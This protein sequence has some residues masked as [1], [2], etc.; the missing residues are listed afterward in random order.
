MADTHQQIDRE[1][2]AGVEHFDEKNVGEHTHVENLEDA[3][4]QN[5]YAVK[6][7]DSDGK[8]PMTPK[9]F[10]TMVVLAMSYVGANLPLFF[11]GGALTFIQAS[12][13]NPSTTGWA[14]TAYGIALAS[15]TPFTGYLQDLFGRRYISIAGSLTLC[16]GLVII[17]TSH[18]FV[19][20]MFGCVISGVGAGATELTAI[21]GLAEVVSVKNRGLT[22]SLLTGFILPFAPYVLYA[23]LFGENATWRWGMWLSLIYNGLVLVGLITLYFPKSHHRADGVKRAQLHK[24]LDLIGGFL[25]MSGIVLLQVF[26]WRGG[27]IYPWKSGRVLAPMIIGFLLCMS[28]FVWEWKGAKYPM[29]PSNIFKGQRVTGSAIGIAFVVGMNLYAILNFL[30][31]MFA[32]VYSPDAIQVGVKALG[33]GIGQTIGST[34]MNLLMTVFKNHQ[35]ENLLFSCLLMTACISALACVNPTNP[36][37]V[38]VLSAFAGW[39]VGGIIA[40]IATVALST[41]PDAFIATVVSIIQACRFL[42]GAIGYSIYYAVFTGKVKTRLPAAVAKYAVD[43]GLPLQS[44]PQFVLAFITAPTTLNKVDGATPQII[45]AATLGSRWAY[46]ESLKYVWLTTIP[47]GALCIILCLFMGSN[48]KYQTNRVAAVSDNDPRSPRLTNSADCECRPW[49]ELNMIRRAAT[50][51]RTDV[52]HDS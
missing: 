25:S 18:R 15:I 9:R 43:A 21:A 3:A 22:L 48:S 47:F 23:Q 5:A 20:L 28:F 39:G 1:S 33:F 2:E 29:V 26:L 17:G 27:S 32:T 6:S 4:T 8:I 10:I 34:V 30:P 42:G 14:T 40:P 52:F 24:E 44:V 46:A 37:T 35:Q 36:N 45:E 49:V 11:V 50:V 31:I 16:I 13:P 12:I 7:D 51:V 38:V 19:Q 41:T